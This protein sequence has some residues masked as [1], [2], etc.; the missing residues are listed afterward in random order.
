M[1]DYEKE[2]DNRL[3]ASPI[4]IQEFVADFVKEFN[5]YI[6]DECLTNLRN[7]NNFE[8][9]NYPESKEDE[10]DEEDEGLLTNIIQ[11]KLEKNNQSVCKIFGCSD[12]EENF[13]FNFTKLQMKKKG[14][15]KAIIN[16]VEKICKEK[17]INL[18]FSDISNDNNIMKKFIP[19]LEKNFYSIVPKNHGLSDA[20]K[21]FQS[22]LINYIQ[23][24]EIREIEK[25]LKQKGVDIN[26]KNINGNT[27]LKEAIILNNQKIVE[28]LLNCREIDVNSKTVNIDAWCVET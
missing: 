15:F 20:V 12:G 28:L 14:Y 6:N 18:I 3:E 17:Q 19:M 7:K 2:F 27:A 25:L 4:E 10:E 16:E 8:Y 23:K 24:N 1:D 9:F 22:K 26:S 21:I 5:E 11:I 13:A